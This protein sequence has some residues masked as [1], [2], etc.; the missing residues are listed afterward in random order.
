M[1]VLTA[2]L[3][4][5]AVAAVVVAT[6]GKRTALVLPALVAGTAAVLAAVRWCELRRGRRLG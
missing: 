3:V 1:A 6:S 2:V 4:A 5:V